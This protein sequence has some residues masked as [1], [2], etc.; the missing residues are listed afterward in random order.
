MRKIIVF[1]FVTLN[2]FYK[3]PK[4]DISWHRHGVEMNMLPRISNPGARCFLGA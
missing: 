4:R 2:G 3:G 1:N